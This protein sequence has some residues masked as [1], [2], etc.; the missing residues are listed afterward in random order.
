LLLLLFP[1]F[2]TL[3]STDL[4][5]KKAGNRFDALASQF[6]DCVEQ[7]GGACLPEKSNLAFQIWNDGIVT[8][9]STLCGLYNP[10][11]LYEGGIEG[12]GMVKGTMPKWCEEGVALQFDE[13][14]QPPKYPCEFNQWIRILPKLQFT[15]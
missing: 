10:H 2:G 5:G 13:R 6:L 14:L 7:I 9:S 8:M 4:N 15:G 1:I 12:K 3:F 11:S